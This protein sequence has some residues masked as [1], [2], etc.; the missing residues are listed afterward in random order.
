[1]AGSVGLPSGKPRAIAGRSR[2]A[3]P[4][5]RSVALERETEGRVDQVAA[6]PV[7]DIEVMKPPGAEVDLLGPRL[8]RIA[9]PADDRDVG[10]EVFGDPRAAPGAG[11]GVEITAAL[12]KNKRVQEID[13][14]WRCVSRHLCVA[15][16]LLPPA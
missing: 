2:G 6:D 8:E 7:L 16:I 12:I 13:T 1:M 14:R 10:D 5:A 11:G 4:Q 9:E 15:G 3:A